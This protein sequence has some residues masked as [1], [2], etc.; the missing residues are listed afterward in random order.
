MSRK[1]TASRQSVGTGSVPAVKDRSEVMA[2]IC[3]RLAEGESLNAICRTPGM[4]TEGAVRAWVRDDADD[5]AEPYR[6][7]RELGYEVW[8][9]QIITLSDDAE[10]DYIEV[11][12]NGDGTSILKFCPE[13]V[14]RS[15]LRVDS[16]KWLLAKALPKVFGDKVAVEATGA[17]GAPLIPESVSSRD[18]ARSVLASAPGRHHRDRARRRRPPGRRRHPVSYTHL[19]LPTILRV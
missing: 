8:A 15:R 16:R 7:A 13:N 5:F 1:R 14:Q 11:G 19:T 17:G 18:L 10:G 3:R 9:D 12:K 2:E 6:Q 4:P